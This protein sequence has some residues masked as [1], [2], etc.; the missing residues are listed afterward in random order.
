MPDD[1]DESEL[2]LSVLTEVLPTFKRLTPQGRERLL[3]T[4]A[5]F[6]G[7]EGV[8]KQSITHEEALVSTSRSAPANLFSSDR[9][10]SPKEFILQKQTR[11]DLERVA[12]LAYYLTH[13]RDLPHFKTIDLSK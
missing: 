4:I 13:Y 2:D 9:S 12:C 7:L 5:T 11:T 10:L 6:F 1:N 8:V 3:Q